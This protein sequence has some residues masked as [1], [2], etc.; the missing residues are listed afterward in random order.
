MDFS[1]ILF[2][3]SSIGYLM[4]EPKLKADKEAGNLS[5]TALT[6]ITDVFIREKY[7]RQ[8]DI[9]NKFIEKGL[10]V[11]EDSITLYSRVKKTFFQKNEEH[12]EN[13][14]VKG[15]PDLYTGESIFEA[16]TIIDIKSSWDI[17]TY[18][19]N[20]GKKV[21]AQYYWQLQTYM[22]LTGAK[23]SVLAYCLVNTPEMMIQDEQK[24]LF[25]KMACLTE[26]ND[27]YREACAHIEL[28]AI[29]D[30]VPLNERVLEFHIDRDDKAIESIKDKVLKARKQISIL[31]EVISNNQLITVH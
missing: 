15:T 27:L 6:H 30:D 25:Y 13:E 18:F 17:F 5:E 29:Y 20:F 2:R 19:R 14:F 16:D 24:K 11:E 9:S 3:A 23:S 4:T 8:T 26:E 10:A 7:G 31:N 12:L 21:N 1:N 22:W 28:A